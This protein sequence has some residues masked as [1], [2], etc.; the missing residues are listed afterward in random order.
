MLKKNKVAIV[1]HFLAHYREPIFRVLCRQQKEIEYTLYS[2][3]VNAYDSVRTINP[4]KAGISVKNNG[5]RW[6]FLKNIWFSNCL[7]QRGVVRLSLSKEFDTII[8][9]GSV[10]FI[11]TWVGAIIAKLRGK[12][13]L[14]WSHGFLKEEKGL[15]GWLRDVFYR[16][17]DGMLLYHKRAKE[18]LIGRGFKPENLYVV[19]NSLDYEKQIKIREAITE[20]D[21]LEYKKRLFSKSHLPVLLFIG[22]IIPQ[23]RLNVLIDA[24]GILREKGQ[25]CNLFFVGDGVEKD[26]LL[27]LATELGLEDSICFYGA[28]YDEEKIALLIMLSDICI[29]PG[30]I[31]LTCM[32]S[33][34]YG[35]PVIT[36]DD[37]DFQ[38]PEYEAIIPGRNG[39]FFKN[40]NAKDLAMKIEEWLLA[41]K[42]REEISRSCYKIIDEYY[43]PN[44]QLKVINSAV[45]AKAPL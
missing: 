2:D 18:I 10:Y 37:P 27:K 4:E 28:C 45:M 23:K 42:D 22:R 36:H 41:N 44:Y 9:L 5:L 32:H 16:L 21:I 34:V 1:Y 14:M 35:T 29:S 8:Y 3:P 26:N 24:A 6:R 33:L 43:N 40:G 13:V 30:E 25:E 11:S 15:K 38:G 39:D 12:R 17:A 19:Y 7:W 20:N 31:G